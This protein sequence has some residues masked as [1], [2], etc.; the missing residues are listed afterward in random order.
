MRFGRPKRPW[1]K[2]LLFRAAALL[3]TLLALLVG[4]EIFVRAFELVPPRI[5]QRD[6]VF[7]T[8][9]ITNQSGYWRVGGQRIFFR[10]NAIGFRGPE[11]S[12][13]KKPG[14]FRVLIIGDS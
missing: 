7:G 14:V 13:S 6:P 12:W 11:V 2:G 9:L 10:I 1:G 3:M 8:R 5:E 4:A